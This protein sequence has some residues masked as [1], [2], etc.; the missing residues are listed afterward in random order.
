MELHAE[1]RSVGRVGFDI[2]SKHRCSARDYYY[3]AF[4]LGVTAI[5]STGG[6]A[7]WAVNARVGMFTS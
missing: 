1:G 5:S 7:A 2:G 3:S 4:A 6:T